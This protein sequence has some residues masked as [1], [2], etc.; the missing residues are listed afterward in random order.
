MRVATL[1]PYITR[2]NAP[3]SAKLH[4]ISSNLKYFTIYHSAMQQAYNSLLKSQPLFPIIFLAPSIAIC[5]AHCPANNP[6]VSSSLA[7][8][9]KLK[10]TRRSFAIQCAGSVQLSLRASGL[11]RRACAAPLVRPST[12]VTSCYKRHPPTKVTNQSPR[13]DL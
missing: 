4:C 13:I 6:A 5:A 1:P 8:A 11:A 10:R 9:S 2:Q 3:E 12:R 7:G